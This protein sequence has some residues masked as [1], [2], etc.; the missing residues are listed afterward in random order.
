MTGGPVRRLNVFFDVDYTLL[1]AG[2]LRNHTREV[3][4]RLTEAGHAIYIWSGVGIRR[5]EIERHDLHEFVSGYFVK[6]L[7]RYRER[8][9][10][11]RVTVMPDF[12]I[13]DYPGV[14]EAFDAGYHVNDYWPPDDAELLDV[15]AAIEAVA[16]QELSA[17]EHEQ[18]GG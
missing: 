18:A 7:S 8:L 14:V 1:N 11:Y 16:M 4:E 17:P 6:P 13:D 9:P 3:F 5:W 12:V 10:D 2:R 15:L